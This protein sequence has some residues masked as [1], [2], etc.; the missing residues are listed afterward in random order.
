MRMI[1]AL[2]APIMAI[3]LFRFLMTEEV[4]MLIFEVSLLWQFIMTI[5]EFL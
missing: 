5:K 4:M 1:S 3:C 2:K